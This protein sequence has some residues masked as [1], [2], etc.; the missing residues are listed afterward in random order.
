[1]RLYLRLTYAVVLVCSLSGCGDSPS[2]PTEN[3]GAPPLVATVEFGP[4][5]SF[6]D[7]REVPVRF[8]SRGVTLSGSL[9]L[10]GTRGRYG[11]VVWVHGS[12]RQGRIPFDSLWARAFVERGHFFF[13][14]DKRGVGA[15]GGSCCPLDFPLL[16][17]DALAAVT[18]LRVH[19]EVAGDAIGLAGA[20]QAGWIVPIAAADAPDVPFVILQSGPTV[21]LGEEDYFSE[22]TRDFDC[23]RGGLPPAEADARVRARGPSGFDPRPHLS[24]M[25]QPGLWLYGLED[26]QQPSRLSID[27]LQVFID[28]G[29][30]FTYL[31]FPGANHF[32]APGSECAASSPVD[33]ITPMFDWLSLRG[34]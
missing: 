33:F 6:E 10:P 32:L 28:E 30:D 13:S 31:S 3:P 24:R 22:L 8:P 20:S 16:A 2:G 7:H 11:G 25:T 17:A 14:F 19:G 18:S 26:I 12:G 29:K 4:E 27:R 15:S 9:Y 5:V 1:M 23:G 34:F 21:T